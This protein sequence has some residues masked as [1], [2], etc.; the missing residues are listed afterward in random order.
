MAMLKTKQAIEVNVDLLYNMRTM[1]SSIGAEVVTVASVGSLA[2]PIGIGNELATTTPPHLA[3]DVTPLTANRELAFPSRANRLLAFVLATTMALGATPEAS[4][5]TENRISMGINV[6]PL[7]PENLQICPTVSD[8]AI[9]LAARLLQNGT[10]PLYYR[11]RKE[12]L[13]AAQTIQLDR[14]QQNILATNFA[15]IDYKHEV[16]EQYGLTVFDID[17]GDL[18]ADIDHKRPKTHSLYR[19]STA[20]LEPIPIQTYIDRTQTFL[21]QYGLTLGI[22]MTDYKHYSQRGALLSELDNDRVK[23]SLYNLMEFF[24]DKIPKELVQFLD[25]DPVIPLLIDD[26]AASLEKDG[27]AMAWMEGHTHRMAINVSTTV[28]KEA[29]AHELGHAISVQ[30]CGYGQNLSYQALN[31]GDDGVYKVKANIKMVSANTAIGP[32]F[33]ATYNAWKAK[34]GGDTELAAR[35][36]QHAKDMQTLI[37]FL[38]DNAPSESEENADIWGMLING[39]KRFGIDLGIIFNGQPSPLGDKILLLFAQLTQY[40]PELAA[41]V[42]S[43]LPSSDL[44]GLHLLRAAQLAR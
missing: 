31:R 21:A 32:I 8:E 7:P 44:S 26:P 40:N 14:K 1:Y 13:A 2:T 36:E 38:T 39:G 43:R 18:K 28:T 37:T 15:T 9:V 25:L 23:Q 35:Y 33:K 20:P 22:G 42:A 4:Q 29:F 16:A 12:R 27:A 30:V 3:P 19:E 10:T 17:N 6:L 34:Q 41:W 24:A 5:P 11:L